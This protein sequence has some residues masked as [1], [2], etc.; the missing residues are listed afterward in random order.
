MSKES[1][2]TYQ[3]MPAWHVSSLLRQ[4]V[5]L[6]LWALWGSVWLDTIDA[7][8]AV[9]RKH[10]GCTFKETTR[11]TDIGLIQNCLPCLLNR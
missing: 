3:S 5:D 11:R 6:F 1:M 4:K 9:Q 2:H 8:F 10:F 7:H